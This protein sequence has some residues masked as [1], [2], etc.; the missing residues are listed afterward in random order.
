MASSSPILV[1]HVVEHVGK[2]PVEVTWEKMTTVEFT[3]THSTIV[4]QE[5]GYAEEVVSSGQP[6]GS[7]ILF[8]LQVSREQDEAH[9]KRSSRSRHGQT[10]QDLEL[11][12][13]SLRSFKSI[14]PSLAT[15]LSNHTN[16]STNNTAGW[17]AATV[18]GAEG[19]N[20]HGLEREASE[21]SEHWC[22]VCLE[23]CRAEAMVDVGQC[24]C[25]FC[26]PCLE[27]YLRSKV[28]S[29]DVSGIR[30]PSCSVPLSAHLLK[31]NLPADVYAR[32]ELFVAL[33]QHNRD[34]NT[35]WCP[36]LNC[37]TPVKR[38]PLSG[39]KT[40]ADH[41]HEQSESKVTCDKCRLDFCFECGT[42][43]HEGMTCEESERSR[44]GKKGGKGGSDEKRFARWVQKHTR[45]CPTCKSVIEKVADGSCNHMICSCCH[46]EFCWLCGQKIPPEGHFEANNFRGCPGMQYGVER[47]SR[48]EQLRTRARVF[49]RYSGQH[50]ANAA[51][52]T[53][54]A[55]VVLAVA[56]V[57]IAVGIPVAAAYGARTL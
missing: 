41:S 43:W 21:H 2:Q 33:G 25:S 9:E 28:D 26:A 56:P 10:S 31:A 47:L 17:S 6:A 7:S 54:K 37:N 36:T 34:P 39:D 16:A 18:L 55:L 53:G 42:A 38:D 52:W 19:V 46:T 27:G 45:K 5:G 23:Y 32:Y 22:A 51:M 48:K 8:A 44:M 11:T 14:T 50:T 40:A 12:G 30:C 1:K 29:G 20:L 13:M 4:V 15:A 35:R 24:G 3:S 57:A 49:V